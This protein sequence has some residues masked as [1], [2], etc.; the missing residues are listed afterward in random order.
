MSV[1]QRLARLERLEAT[2]RTAAD[3]Y[4][5]EAWSRLAPWAI[6]VHYAGGWEAA[7]AIVKTGGRL[8]APDPYAGQ[9]GGPTW[10]APVFWQCGEVRRFPSQQQTQEI[11]S[12][13]T[14]AVEQLLGQGVPEAEIVRWE[15]GRQVW[16]AI[17]THVM[18]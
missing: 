15:T 6:A 1:A 11:L 5:P 17:V 8:P 13:I 10:D 2:Q 3:G 14:L 7:V 16:Q 12:C 18:L 9:S 4:A